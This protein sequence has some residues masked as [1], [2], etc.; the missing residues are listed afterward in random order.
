MDYCKF[1][2][3]NL[4]Y[5]PIVLT[6]L[7]GKEIVNPTK[8]QYLDAGYL[9]IVYTEQ[10]SPIKGYHYVS[11]IQ[12]IE[13]VPTQ[14]WTSVKD[15]ITIEDLEKTMLVMDHAIGQYDGVLTATLTNNQTI[16]GI[17]FDVDDT[18]II[19]YI[20]V[21]FDKT[22]NAGKTFV[23]YAGNTQL[24]ATKS[25]TDNIHKKKFTFS[26]TGNQTISFGIANETDGTLLKIKDLTIYYTDE[27][28]QTVTLDN[29]SAVNSTIE[30]TDIFV[31]KNVG[32][33]IPIAVYD[34]VSGEDLILTTELIKVVD[35]S[36]YKLTSNAPFN[37]YVLCWNDK[38]G[39][40]DAQEV[41]DSNSPFYGMKFSSGYNSAF[42][43][44]LDDKYWTGPY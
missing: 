36:Y 14:V 8:Q 32:L 31:Y 33:H 38:Y 37:A 20:I 12:N 9:E 39:G 4:I 13:G 18:K 40:E 22:S 17:S 23:L 6:S 42:R 29:M 30:V 7:E 26:S 43:Q 16:S 11:E 34:A 19:D 1:E 5:A 28:T 35:T 25:S 24:T 10:P 15:P 44:S 27:S 21:K 2:D 41:T 3:G